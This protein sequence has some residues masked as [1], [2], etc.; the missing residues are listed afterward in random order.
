MLTG[1]EIEVVL[2]TKLLFQKCIDDVQAGL[3]S[4]DSGCSCVCH[5]S[6]LQS[7]LHYSEWRGHS[8]YKFPTCSSP[9]RVIRAAAP[10]YPVLRGLI[11]PLYS[12]RQKSSG[13]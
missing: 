2:E 5:D 9:L 12:A 11:W 10:H 3:D 1:G 13:C 7:D 4:L 6:T 8:T